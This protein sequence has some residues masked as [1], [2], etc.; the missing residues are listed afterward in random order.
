MSE[1]SVSQ[2]AIYRARPTLRIGGEADERAT[3]LVLAMRMEESE[4]GLSRLELRF[5]N[6]ASTSDGGAE[7]AF[8]P[9]SKLALGAEIGVYVG[10][11]AAPREIFKGKVSAIEIDFKTG[12]PPE[13]CALA[14]DALQSAR[15]AR[16]SKTYTDKSPADVV[17]D[18]AGVLGLRPTISGLDA[19]TGTWAQLNESDLA[20]LRRLLARF[21]ADL[22]ISGDELQVSP[23][24]DVQRGTLELQLYGQLGRARVIA[25]LADQVTAVSV[26]GWNARDGEAVDA[27]ISSGAHIGPG[28]G[29]TGAEL[30]QQHF[31]A[32]REH[33]AHV[34]VLTADEANA[35][36]QAAFDQ[37]ARRFVRVDAT[38]EGNP[39]LRV[40]SE[41][42][43]SGLDPRF[44]NHYYVVRACHLYDLRIGYR[45]EFSA[46]CAYLGSGS[47]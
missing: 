29:Q 25:D 47:T 17:R 26:R 7:T 21:D 8:G 45:T 19:P 1:T 44:D 32:R 2:S 36:A 41:V 20:F 3:E 46:E 42:A 38:A 27:D 30:L 18:V 37:R 23:R 10:D 22:Q 11:E 24:S 4:G 31:E 13:I 6:V 34:P 35:V 15:M 39:K 5:S 12:M 43:L 14:E 28:Q 33:L 16:R 40:G 9:D